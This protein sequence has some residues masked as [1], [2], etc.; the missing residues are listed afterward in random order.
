MKEWGKGWKWEGRFEKNWWCVSGTHPQHF[1]KATHC[2]NVKYPLITE[3]LH[4]VKKCN[5]QDNI[6]HTIWYIIKYNIICHI[7]FILLCCIKLSDFCV[8]LQPVRCICNVNLLY[9]ST[10]ITF[11]SQFTH[12]KQTSILIIHIIPKIA[13]QF[14]HNLNN[15]K[16]IPYYFTCNSIN[17]IKLSINNINCQK[18]PYNN[19]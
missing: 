13:S 17:N 18:T 14:H 2:F 10:F 16:T 5:C 4:I 3:Y 1:R 7:I 9:F 8:Y 15:I 11:P 6:I 19:I 12:I